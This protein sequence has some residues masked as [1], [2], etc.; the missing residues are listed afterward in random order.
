MGRG[1]TGGRRWGLVGIGHSAASG[2]S[3]S[4]QRQEGPSLAASGQ[5][6]AF[7]PP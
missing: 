1:A 2:V 4:W 6:V 3:G 5:R 7:L